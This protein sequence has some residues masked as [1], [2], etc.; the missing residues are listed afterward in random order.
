MWGREQDNIG[1]GY[2]YLDG[3]GQTEES[4][5]NS[6]VAEAYV[7]FGLH[8]YLALTFDVQHMKDSYVVSENDVDGW[9]F[10]LRATCEF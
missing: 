10:G 1:I 6:H 8:E 7:R 4:L 2:A 9:I 5:K 3:A